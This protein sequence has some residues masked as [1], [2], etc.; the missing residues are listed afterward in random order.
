MASP[1]PAHGPLAAAMTTLAGT[2]DHSPRVETLLVTIA[3]LATDRVAAADRAWVSALRDTAVAVP[4][5]AGRGDTVAVLNLYGHDRAAMASLGAGLGVVQG[6]SGVATD[7]ARLAG[8]D[9]GGRE[10]VAGHAHALT[11]RAA[12]RLAIEM[13]RA[14]YRCDPEDAYLCLWIQAGEAGID[15]GEAAAAVI[16]GREAHEAAMLG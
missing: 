8:M 14:E 4:L 15:L 13:I 16:A 5:Y 6:R 3:E 11:I 2:P 7:A 9:A 10:L 12:I 1:L